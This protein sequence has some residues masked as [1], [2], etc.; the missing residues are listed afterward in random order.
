MK[1]SASQTKDNISS[2]YTRWN[3][4]EVHPILQKQTIQKH[5]VEHCAAEVEKQTDQ[6]VEAVSYD[7]VHV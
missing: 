7:S 1:M 6:K 5:M 4:F 2:R 3:Y